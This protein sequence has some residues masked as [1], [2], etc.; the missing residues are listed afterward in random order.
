MVSGSKLNLRS[1]WCPQQGGHLSKLFV[2][3]LKILWWKTDGNREK[4]GENLATMVFDIINIAFCILAFCNSE[5]NN[6]KDFKFSEYL[7]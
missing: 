2:F 5:R 6:S 4:I 3:F 7:L 1:K